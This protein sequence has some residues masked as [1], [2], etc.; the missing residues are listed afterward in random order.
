MI[1]KTISII[2]VA[3]CL[4]MFGCN[5]QSAD[6]PLT[7]D[8]AKNMIKLRGYEPTEIGFVK[9]VKSND[10]IIFKTFYDA[11]ISPNAKD[12]KGET[13]LNA[14]IQNSELKTIKAL[15]EK[16]DI[17]LKDGLGNSP[18]FLA[19]QKKNEDALNY[20]L[21][22]GADVN[23]S[24]TAGKITNQS[25]LYLAVTRGREDLITK[26]LDKG[27]NPNAADNSNATPLHEICVGSGAS[28]EIVKQ[29]LAKGAN[30]NVQESNGATPLI[31]IA[32][33]KE[34]DA[35]TRT[36]VA[37]LL[38]ANKADKNLKS[39]EGKTALMWAKQVG[40]NDVLS[41]LK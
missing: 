18:L 14:A 40:N 8:M 21:E 36:E 25:L 38:L 39:K 19:F 30:P 37:K 1:K 2:I 33:N 15:A 16:A 11:G 34:L 7:P 41:L 12:E 20:L 26:L 22:K 23:A 29:L 24:G 13:A 31:Y 35:V 28:V 27:A 10:T 17:N 32:S 5:S 9:A 3:V 6:T 4:T